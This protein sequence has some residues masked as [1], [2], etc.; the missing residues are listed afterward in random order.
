MSPTEPLPHDRHCDAEFESLVR[1]ICAR[2]GMYV[3]QPS[4]HAVCCYLDGFNVG[5]GGG[6][7][8]GFR[9]WLIVRAN[10]GNNLHWPEL[11]RRL[12]E[13]GQS[14]SQVSEEERIKALGNRIDEFL[15]YRNDNG[16]TKVFYEYGR[17]L[18]RKRWYRGPL[19]KR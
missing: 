4:Y 18:L 3:G 5:R 10:S 14:T 2:P 19:R 9:E 17:W 16:I 1:S 11:V 12:S 13:V 7:L 8:L 6:P 15:R